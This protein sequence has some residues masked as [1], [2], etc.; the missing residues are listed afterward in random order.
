M[1]ELA[2]DVVE[3]ILVRMDVEDLIRCKSVCKSW[4]SLISSPRFVKAHLNHNI[5]SDRDNRELGHRRVCL[6]YILNEDTWFCF[7][8][9]HIVG[10]C[11]GLLCFSPRG[12]ELVVTNPSTREHRKLPTP[13]H[14]PKVSMIRQ[15]L[16]W[17]F[18]YD[19]CTDDYKVIVGFKKSRNSNRTL[20]Y[21]FTLKSNTWKV[22]G[23]LNY[24]SA[25][26]ATGILCGGALH[27]FM[28]DTRGKKTIIS[29]DLSTE[30]VKKI[31][32]PIPSADLLHDHAYLF[33]ILGVI[34]GCLCIYSNYSSS[35]TKIWVVMKNNKWQLY[36]DDH[37]QSRYDVAHYVQITPNSQ[38]TGCDCVDDGNL[39]PINGGYIRAG[40]FVRS[41]LSPH[42]H[43]NHDDNN[44]NHCNE[45]KKNAKV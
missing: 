24:K 2:F 42:L 15:V 17:G 39:V 23:G 16:C 45:R 30:E 6:P 22:I 12:S 34:E 28:S 40:I 19:S 44:H 11:N 18:G 37:C 21:I 10:S 1:A 32:L 8:C 20:F 25:G 31:P 29:L 14:M 13:R 4:L 36:N 33:K 26:G 7:D 35:S 43:V 41:L 38:L 5:K 9:I 27:W 3:Q